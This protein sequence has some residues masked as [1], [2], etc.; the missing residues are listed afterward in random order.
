MLRL[1]PALRPHAARL[2]TGLLAASLLAC[3]GTARRAPAGPPAVAW[4]E[5]TFALRY[6]PP[7]CLADR[8]SLHA[9]VQTPTG[10]ERVSLEEADD[11]AREVDTVL[12]QFAADPH[13]ALTIEGEVLRETRLWM[14]NHAAR[15]L[16]VD[17]V[18]GPH[19]PADGDTEAQPDEAD[20]ALPGAAQ[21]APD[22]APPPPGP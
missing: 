13:A 9:E 4:G 22:P 7:T 18:L 14:G 5:G 15:V 11:D 2:A 19:D 16:R 6:N 21:P 20:D 17:R 3:G 12:A 8:P 10:W 1:R